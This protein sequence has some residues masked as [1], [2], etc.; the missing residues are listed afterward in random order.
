[1]VDSWKEA[2]ATQ[3]AYADQGKLP[4]EYAV[5][6]SM[7]LLAKKICT[8]RPLKILNLKCYGLSQSLSN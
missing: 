3:R 4:K 2:A 1:M 5:S 8:K 6:D 7:W